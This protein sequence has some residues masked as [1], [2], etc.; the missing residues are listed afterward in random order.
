MAYL[1]DIRRKISEKEGLF[2]FSELHLIKGAH[3]VIAGHKGLYSVGA[4]LIVIRRRGGRI[5]VRGEGL[6]VLT[7][8][9]S[10]IEL[11]GKIFAVEYLSE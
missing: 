2:S 3:C 1:Q 9:Q 5:A 6:R 8:D 11:S 7:A 4:D 10:E